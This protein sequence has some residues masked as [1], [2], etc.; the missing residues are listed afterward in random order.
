MEGHRF[1]DLIFRSQYVISNFCPNGICIVQGYEVQF[2]ASKAYEQLMIIIV[3]LEISGSMK[4][5]CGH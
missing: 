1:R 3:G 4:G 2:L 5:G